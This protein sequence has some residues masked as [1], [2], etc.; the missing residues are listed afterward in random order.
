MCGVYANEVD[1]I[2]PLHRG[3]AKY[4]VANLRAT[5]RMCHIQKTR[6]EARGEATAAEREW[7]QFADALR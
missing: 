1:H 4:D 5:C 7:Q 6:V 2:V 3:G